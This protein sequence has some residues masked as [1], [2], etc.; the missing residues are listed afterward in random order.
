M[1]PVWNQDEC[2]ELPVHEIH[3]FN[4]TA[5]PQSLEVLLNET[6]GDEWLYRR[7]VKVTKPLSKFYL[8]SNLGIKFL[9]PE[10][11]LLY[12]SKRPRWKDEQ[13]F[14]AVVNYLNVES[15]EW[16]KNTL[17]VCYSEHHWLQ[18]L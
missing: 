13:D 16:L 9:R 10:V 6:D 8:T 4:E 12:K 15:K 2:L 3:C 18:K 5:E 11:V 17:I 7:N 14:E 1:L